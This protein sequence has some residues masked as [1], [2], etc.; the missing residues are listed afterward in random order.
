MKVSAVIA[1]YNPFHNG[2][3]YMLEKV[4][5][6][7][8]A[9]VIIMSGGFVQRGSIAVADKWTRARAA[10]LNGADLVIELPV[11]YALNTA[12]R[13]A[14]GGVYL[15]D[16]IG[17]AELCFGSE[18]GDTD[19]LINAADKLS[20]E[21][22]EVSQKIKSFISEGMN[23]PSAR[24]R[25]YE[26]IIDG[27]ILS[28]PNNILAAEYICAAKRLNSTINFR[29]IKRYAVG[30]D[31]AEVTAATASASAIRARLF[32]GADISSFVPP[33]AREITNPYDL[34]RLDSAILY[35]LR[36]YSTEKLALIND[37]SEGLENRIKKLSFESSSFDELCEKIKTKRYTRSRI[38][39]IVLSAYLNLTKEL[40]AVNPP[41]VRIL[42]M[43]GTGIK[44]LGNIKHSCPLPIITK[45]AD[46]TADDPVFLADLRAGEAF[47]LCAPEAGLRLGGADFKNSPIVL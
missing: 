3:K 43:N 9:A 24:S 27:G 25:A 16:A 1:E 18:S 4:K 15:A 38:N 13:F 36:N 33:G 40:C 46:Y 11:T 19:A 2:H 5:E 39:R 35:T 32:K 28:A 44:I 47:S 42:G 10:L 29:A 6:N 45:T 21:P 26:G 37:V 31:E 20:D 17:A 12:Q 30:H 23:Y 14:Y 8:D 7:S 22:E 41:Y 34:S